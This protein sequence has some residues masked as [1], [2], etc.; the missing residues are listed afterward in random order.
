MDRLSDVFEN[1]MTLKDL[2][3]QEREISDEYLK[4]ILKKEK[5]EKKSNQKLSEY[6]SNID[7]KRKADDFDRN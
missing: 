4:I 1:S 5:I 2:K 3:D 6:N 7:K